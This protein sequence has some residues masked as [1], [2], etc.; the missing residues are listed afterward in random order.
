MCQSQFLALIT[1]LSEF[2][3][4]HLQHIPFKK[5]LHQGEMQHMSHPAYSS[6]PWPCH[7]AV[8]RRVLNILPLNQVAFV[9][10]CK[11]QN[12]VEE[13]SHDFRS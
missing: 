12:G 13:M 2:V 5:T 3:H 11:Q 10:V 4:D 7:S 9:F 8:K 6:V 1:A